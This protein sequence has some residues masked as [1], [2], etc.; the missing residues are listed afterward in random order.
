MKLEVLLLRDG[1]IGVT[2]TGIEGVDDNFTVAFTATDASDDLLVTRINN[3][4]R[5]LQQNVEM[6]GKLK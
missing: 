2:A 4:L 1:V 5:M 3:A 6:S